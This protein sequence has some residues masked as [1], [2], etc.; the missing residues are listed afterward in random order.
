MG[1]RG[2]KEEG[3]GGGRGRKVAESAHPKQFAR[4]LITIR[5]LVLKVCLEPSY[6]G[7]F[8]ST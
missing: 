4:K 5:E 7:L 2:A 1:S 6:P 3:G 8:L